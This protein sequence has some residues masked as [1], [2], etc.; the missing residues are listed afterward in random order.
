MYNIYIYTHIYINY[1]TLTKEIKEIEW[2]QRSSIGR[3]NTV[4]FQ[5]FPAWFIDSM[6]SPKIQQVIYGYWQT[7]VKVDVERQ[8]T[9]N[10]QLKMQEQSWKSDTIWL[11]DLLYSYSHQD[12]VVLVN[13]DTNRS[14]KNSEPRNRPR[15][16]NQLKF[17]KRANATQWRKDSVFTNGTG[18]TKYSYTRK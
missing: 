11:Q 14:I 1:K 8:K 13:E 17:D 18:P 5:F 16:Y 7:N 6:Q 12:S 4:K 3:H 2:F 10:S 15:E 9:Q